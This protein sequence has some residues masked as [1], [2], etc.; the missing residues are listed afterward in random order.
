VPLFR[1]SGLNAVTGERLKRA[2]YWVLLGSLPRLLGVTAET[3]AG[4]PYLTVEPSGAGGVGVKARGSPS[5]RS[6]RYRSL[7]DDAAAQLEMLGQS[8]DPAATGATDFLETARIIAGLDLVITVDTSI[9]HLAGALGKP[10]W[11]LLASAHTDWRWLRGRSDSPWYASARLYRQ[12]RPRAWDP[13]LRQVAADLA[14]E[15]G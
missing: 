9:A 15:R 7:P 1:A 6:D 13:V 14:S 3:L 12:D 4:A 10:V 8:L 11:I 5:H 2:D